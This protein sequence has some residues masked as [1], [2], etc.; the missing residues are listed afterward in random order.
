MAERMGEKMG[1]R[2]DKEWEKGCEEI[3]IKDESLY[4]ITFNSNVSNN[5]K[6]Q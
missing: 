6:R 3:I 2:G 4:I 1:E 5:F